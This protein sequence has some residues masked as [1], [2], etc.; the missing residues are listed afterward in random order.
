MSDGAVIQDVQLGRL[1]DRRLIVAVKGG[2]DGVG[3]VMLGLHA[4]GNK[5]V[6]G[7]VGINARD[8]EDQGAFV[9]LGRF[10]L[11]GPEVLRM[12]ANDN[13]L[14]DCHIAWFA[15]SWRWGRVG[16]YISPR[17]VECAELRDGGELIRQR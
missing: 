14:L 9:A 4:V 3:D 16:L 1:T 15:S 6:L 7:A 8:G 13:D 11:D 5:Q 2:G 10:G 12:I 17:W